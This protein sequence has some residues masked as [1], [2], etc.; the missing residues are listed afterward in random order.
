MYIMASSDNNNANNGDVTK[1]SIYCNSHCENNCRENMGAICFSDGDDVNNSS[2]KN[3]KPVI[4]LYEIR[5]LY[6]FNNENQHIDSN[7]F[8]KFYSESYKYDKD[9]IEILYFHYLLVIGNY[10]SIHKFI[11]DFIN[12][13]S[14][15]NFERFVN[16]P[17]YI[18]V[19]KKNGKLYY[20]NEENINKIYHLYPVT[21]YIMWN[22]K[23]DILR[24]LITFG[25]TLDK[26]DNFGYYPEEAI[27]FIPYFNPVPHLDKF[28]QYNIIKDNDMNKKIYYRNIDEFKQ[29]INEV[30]YITGEDVS[31]N[32]FYP[33]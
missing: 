25:T 21:T 33:I 22:N 32:W 6:G 16:S 3:V 15:D 18:P 1:K 13:S 31:Y 4:S 14:I 27:K 20:K 26:T 19:N 17:L 11:V 23:P 24:L 30:R 29:V 2:T 7:S 12:T 28:E 5:E 8:Y 10:R 9:Y